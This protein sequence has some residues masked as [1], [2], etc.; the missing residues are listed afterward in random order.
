MP[1]KRLSI[2]AHSEA[3]G[4][5]TLVSAKI[6]NPWKKKIQVTKPSH[7]ELKFLQESNK[8]FKCVMFSSSVLKSPLLVDLKMI[9]YLTLCKM[10]LSFLLCLAKLLS[11]S[12]ENGHNSSKWGKP[13]SFIFT[14]TQKSPLMP[15]FSRGRVLLLLV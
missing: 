14:R 10:R 6:N 1:S 7:Q 12:K 13:N 11:S 8:K 5:L 15:V 4:C 9:Q 2:S 3:W